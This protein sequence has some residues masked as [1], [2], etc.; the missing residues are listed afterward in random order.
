MLAV[1]SPVVNHFKNTSDADDC[2]HPAEREASGSCPIK[3]THSPRSS[4][5]GV[6]QTWLLVANTSRLVGSGASV[7]SASVDKPSTVAGQLMARSNSPR[8][9]ASQTWPGVMRSDG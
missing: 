2:R 5:D 1:P 3:N 8:Q 6:S 4:A 7:T 9:A